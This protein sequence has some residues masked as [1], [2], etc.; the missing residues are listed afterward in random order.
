MNGKEDITVELY[1]ENSVELAFVPSLRKYL[2]KKD[3]LK[4]S[5]KQ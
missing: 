3:F 5:E 2:P 1:A 4:E